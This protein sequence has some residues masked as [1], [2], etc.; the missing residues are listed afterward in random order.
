MLSTFKKLPVE[1]QN[2]ILNA[3]ASVFAEEGYHYASISNICKKACISNGALYKYFKNKETL[4]LSVIEFGADLVENELYVK[5]IWDKN[6][7]YEAIKE[8]LTGLMEFDKKNPN[9]IS[10]YSDLG[11]GSMNRFA[12]SA[13]DKFKNATSSYTLKLVEKGKKNGEIR[14]ELSSNLA[15]CLIDNYITLFSYSMVSDYH[16]KRFDSFLSIDGK[17]LNGTERI[18]LIIESLKATLKA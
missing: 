18:D 4:F 11:S 16:A 9:H 5:Y 10:V 17:A 8:L 7:V 12:A 14:K 1:K 13:S 6:S 15:A 2:N 3:A